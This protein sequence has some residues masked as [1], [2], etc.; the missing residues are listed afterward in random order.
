MD[1]CSR[2]Y[3]CSR[4]RTV[5]TYTTVGLQQII[6]LSVKNVYCNFLEPFF[7]TSSPIHKDMNNNFNKKAENFYISET[8]ISKYFAFFLAKIPRQL[9][10]KKLTISIQLTN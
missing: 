10:L 8:G 6:I 1:V 4:N 2:N 3:I 5:T 9:S 7:F